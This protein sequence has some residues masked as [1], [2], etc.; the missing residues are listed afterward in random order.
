MVTGITSGSILSAWA[1]AGPFKAPHGH[2]HYDDLN[3]RLT[4]LAHVSMFMLPLINIVY[5]DHID[6]L[7]ISDSLKILGA[8]SMIV[9][10]FGIP[11]F[12]IMATFKLVFKYLNVIPITAGFIGLCIMAYGQWLKWIG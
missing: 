1:F 10:M 9:L 3:R 8:Y 7:M 11:L 5:G 12:L 4:R 6:E 2:D